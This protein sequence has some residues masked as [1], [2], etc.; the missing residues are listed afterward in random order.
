APS[1][2]E[3][4]Y[5]FDACGAKAAGDV[6][7]LAIDAE[8]LVLVA[9]HVRHGLRGRRRENG[10]TINVLRGHQ[11]HVVVGLQVSLRDAFLED[12]VERNSELVERVTVPAEFLRATPLR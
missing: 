3:S 4:I 11:D 5:S 9:L 10:S 7:R 2:K 12:Q 8:R 1:V 6:R